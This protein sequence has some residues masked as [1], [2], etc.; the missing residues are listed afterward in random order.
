MNEVLSVYKMYVCGFS[1]MYHGDIK[2]HMFL[3][4]MEICLFTVTGIVLHSTQLPASVMYDCPGL[5]E[6]MLLI[7]S[8]KCIRMTICKITLH[9]FDIR[10]RVEDCLKMPVHAAYF[11][12]ECVLTSVSLNSDQCVNAMSNPF[13]GHPLL[14]YVNGIS[15]AWDGC[16]VLSI[17]L[18]SVVDRAR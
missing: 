18:Y 2:L 5:W 12:V 7:L 1:T 11:V 4:F 8:L 16:F 17:A 10:P 14:A 6:S 9:R 15:C 13:G 3:F